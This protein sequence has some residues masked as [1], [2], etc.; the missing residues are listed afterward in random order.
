MYGTWDVVEEEVVLI[1]EDVYDI[2]VFTCRISNK[3]VFGM[4][5]L[6]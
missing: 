1:F 5:L 2:F 6:M 4:M 3:V